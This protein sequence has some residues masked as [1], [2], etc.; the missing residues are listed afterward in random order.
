[1]PNFSQ[2]TIA[3]HTGR[4]PEMRGEVAKVT[5]AVSK[6]RKGEKTTTWFNCSAFG[7]TAELVMRLKKGEPVL[8]VGEIELRQF[9]TKDGEVKQSLDL[10]V[11]EIAFLGGNANAGPRQPAPTPDADSGDMGD[12][13]F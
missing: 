5:V 12:M 7:K 2:C 1:M 4:E 3:G 13:P 11:R 8:F 6:T 10:T 9:T